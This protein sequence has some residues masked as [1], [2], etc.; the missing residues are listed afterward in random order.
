MSATHS[1]PGRSFIKLLPTRSGGGR[2]TMSRRAVTGLPGVAG[3][4]QTGVVHQPPNPFAA[5]PAP[6]RT[7]NV[8]RF[9]IRTIHNLAG[10]YPPCRADVYLPFPPER[11][12][13]QRIHNEEQQN[14]HFLTMRMS[15]AVLTAHVVEEWR[16]GIATGYAP[17]FRSP[18]HAK[19]R[20]W[21]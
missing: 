4:N 12:K 1:W 11:N 6:R 9:G 18:G 20:H 7:L 15:P 17:A 16:G 8:V 3:T 19:V 13:S 10:N 5:M 14:E 2:A 21:H